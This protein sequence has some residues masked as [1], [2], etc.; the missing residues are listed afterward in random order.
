MSSINTKKTE[1]S[2]LNLKTKVMESESILKNKEE[3]FLI[4]DANEWLEIASK[5]TTPKQLFG[6]FWQEGELAIL[7]AGTGLGKSILTV[8][9]ADS[10]SKGEPTLGLPMELEK[11]PILYFDFEN[12]DLQFKN[13][14]TNYLG[15][16]YKFDENLK[17]VTINNEFVNIEEIKR[18]ELILKKIE[19]IVIETG[20]KKL[21]LDNIT[22]LNCDLEKAKDASIFIKALKALSKKYELSILLVGHTPKRFESMPIDLNDLGG[23]K[24]ISNLADSVFAIG[25]SQ[26]DSSYRYIK[27][28]KCR[29]AEMIYT[30]ENVIVCKIDK[31]PNKLELKFIEYGFEQ[32]HLKEVDKQE[33]MTR[34]RRLKSEGKSNVEIGEIF[35]VVEGTIRNWLKE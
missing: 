11:S 5:Q 32:E 10:I 17:R 8:Q 21:A 3:M 6:N 22:Y 12:S 31:Y 13:R 27:Q 30:S 33:R 20:I 14:N 28:L 15:D 35:G 26:K 2:E 18:H 23:S 9:I 7:F 1:T 34:I 19:Q 25:S 24:M 29:S 16:V 4:K